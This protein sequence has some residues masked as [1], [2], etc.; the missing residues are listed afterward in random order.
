[1]KTY[2]KRRSRVI[3]VHLEPDLHDAIK[4]I[5]WDDGRTLSNMIRKLAEARVR[6][7]RHA[8]ETAP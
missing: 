5:A 6:D 3:T 8:L 7:E 1:M 4:Q 2:S